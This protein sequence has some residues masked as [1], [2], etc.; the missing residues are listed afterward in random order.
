M[1]L[2][3]QLPHKIVNV[4]FSITGQNNE[5]TFCGGVDFLK[6]FY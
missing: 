2:E 4:L 5:L 1:V 6:L 3:S